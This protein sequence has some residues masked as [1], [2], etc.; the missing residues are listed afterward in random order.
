MRFFMTILMSSFL[1]GGCGKYHLEERR[2]FVDLPDFDTPVALADHFERVGIVATGMLIP[3][4][5]ERLKALGFE[6]WEIS[7]DPSSFVQ[8]RKRVFTDEFERRF[9]ENSRATITERGSYP[10]FLHDASQGACRLKQGGRVFRT[11]GFIFLARSGRI[12]Y[13][14]ARSS[15][16]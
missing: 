16:T 3:T 7:T 11:Y 12:V 6:C 5:V 10:S 8:P 4:V 15:P 2:G 9:Y 14:T 13:Y 1:I